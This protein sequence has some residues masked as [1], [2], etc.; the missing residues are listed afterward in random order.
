MSQERLTIGFVRRGYSATG[1]A[2]AYLKRLGRGVV[3]AGHSAQLFATN[4]WPQNEWPF[5]AI[6][7]LGSG[8]TIAFADEM[9][10]LRPQIRCDVWMSLERVWRCHVYRAGDGVHRAWLERRANVATRL[11]GLFRRLHH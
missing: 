9:E 5:G 1:G 11:Q 8:S 7:R 6:M 2:E 4:N 10:Q 3:D